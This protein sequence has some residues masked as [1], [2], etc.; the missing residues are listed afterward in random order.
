MS[1]DNDK[2]CGPAIEEGGAD[3]GEGQGDTLQHL[4]QPETLADFLK[5]FPRY[6]IAPDKILY[7]EGKPVLHT[8]YIIFGKVE[9]RVAGEVIGVVKG[10]AL[11]GAEEC[12][13]R[14]SFPTY[15][16]T[17]VAVTPTSVVHLDRHGLATVL[18]LDP[19]CAA[20]YLQFQAGL[21]KTV[22]EKLSGFK[23]RVTGQAKALEK[24]QEA[25]CAQAPKKPGKL[26]PPPGE[27]LKKWEAQC[28]TI[29]VLL[30]VLGTRAANLTGLLGELQKVVAAHPDWQKQGDFAAFVRYVE[31]IV[32]RDTNPDIFSP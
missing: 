21:R 23:G 18:R 20:N 25:L 15:V 22:T 2:T 9:V 7:E 6:Q 31:E 3:N 16:H 12:H 32:A 10:P 29:G 19:N 30:Q 8:F 5:Q 13:F 28:G 17:A 1:E 14:V 26:P 11:L 24:V 4:P 27:L